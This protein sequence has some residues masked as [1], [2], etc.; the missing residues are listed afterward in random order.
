MTALG[1]FVGTAIYTF[2]LS[3]TNSRTM[4]STDLVGFEH[5]VRLFDA[6]RWNTAMVN[7]GILCVTY[8]VGCLLLGFLLAAALDRKIRFENTLRTLFL[9]PQAV[10]FVVTGL[11]WQW[12][13]NPNL[14]IQNT[15]QGWGWDSFRFDWI[16]HPET[17]I[18]G[19]ALAGLWQGAG[20]AMIILLA[21]LRGIDGSLWQAARVEGIPLWRTYV[22][23]IIP[24][25]RAA[26]ATAAT[27][28]FMGIIRTYDLVV[29]MT[30]GGPGSSTELPA[31]FIMDNLF[32]RQNIGLATAG[33]SVLLITV[34]AVVVP[35]FFVRAA[36]QKKARKGH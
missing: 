10:S 5:Y 36:Q 14:G 17:A 15:L 1:L 30:N 8:V 6:R 26:V 24:E 3:F 28:L 23:I 32:N 21:G 29:A 13:M 12:L 9:Y 2:Y 20:L 11:V 7:M 35:I 16:E 31:K 25:M 19:V 27:L 18:Y 22:S 4:P 33:A 34:L